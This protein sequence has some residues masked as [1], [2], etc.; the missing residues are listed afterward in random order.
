MNR[1]TQ[2]AIEIGVNTLMLWVPL[3]IFERIPRC[4]RMLFRLLDAYRAHLDRIEL[5]SRARRRS[6]RREFSP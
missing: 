6:H 2:D 1:L 3:K 4:R 5:E